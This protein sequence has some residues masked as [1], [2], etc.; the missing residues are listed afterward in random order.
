MRWAAR[1][2]RTVGRR[3]LQRPRSWGGGRRSGRRRRD[4]WLDRRRRLRRPTATRRERTPRGPGSDSGVRGVRRSGARA[5]LGGPGVTLCG[6][7]GRLWGARATLRAFTRRSQSRVRA[8][9]PAARVRASTPTA[10]AGW[11]ARPR[12]PGLPPPSQPPAT[13][14]AQPLRAVASRPRVAAPRAPA[15]HRSQQGPPARARAQRPPSVGTRAGPTDAERRRARDP[16]PTASGLAP[17]WRWQS[18]DGDR[19]AAAVRRATVTR[20]RAGAAA[21]LGLDAARRTTG[22]V[23]SLGADDVSGTRGRSDRFGYRR[24]RSDRLGLGPLGGGRPREHLRCRL[25][26]R[27]LWSRCGLAWRLRRRSRS[28]GGGR[29]RPNQV[30]ARG[31]TGTPGCEQVA[32][33]RPRI[34]PAEEQRAAPGAEPGSRA[35]RAPACWAQRVAPPAVRR[36]A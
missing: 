10:P 4:G 11:Q 6:A 24:G 23:A 9:A 25:G 15:G 3:S 8:T 2:S 17:Q 14:A 28:L 34:A 32:T 29:L 16:R 19:G 21:G 35:R 7:R 18:L 36:R 5:T 13:A 27:R 22:R 20:G 33:F 31:P 1:R 26:R 30:G 12:P